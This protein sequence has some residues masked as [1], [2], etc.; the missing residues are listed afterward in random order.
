MLLI[1]K[2]FLNGNDY[3]LHSATDTV[4]VL[5]HVAVGSAQYS[6]SLNVLAKLILVSD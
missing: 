5:M 4:L 1:A 2:C 3:Y 6:T